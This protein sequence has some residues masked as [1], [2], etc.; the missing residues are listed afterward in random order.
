MALLRPQSLNRIFLSS[1]PA[2]VSSTLVSH[3]STSR[4]CAPVR[5]K[6]SSN[7]TRRPRSDRVQFRTY[8]TGTP[9]TMPLDPSEYVSGIFK[10]GIFSMNSPS[11]VVIVPCSRSDF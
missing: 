10:E 5:T 7:R 6:D 1:R 4:L 3:R 2:S 9:R 8:W 11:L